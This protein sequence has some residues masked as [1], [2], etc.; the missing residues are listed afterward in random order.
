MAFGCAVWENVCS[1]W[2]GV[3][4]PASQVT[5]YAMRVK[6]ALFGSS[7]PFRVTVSDG[8]PTFH[9]W[10]IYEGSNTAPVD[11][12][13]LDVISLDSS[14]E[15]IRPGSSLVV[16]PSSGTKTKVIASPGQLF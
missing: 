2:S 15:T 16:D 10:L 4:T 7:A 6:A 8:D 12:E 1:G 13:E 3:E 11:H 9:E 5:V 14:Y